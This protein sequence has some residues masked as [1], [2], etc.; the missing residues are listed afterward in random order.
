MDKKKNQKVPSSKITIW[1]ET[2]NG[3]SWKNDEKFVLQLR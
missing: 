3:N 2:I 1:S